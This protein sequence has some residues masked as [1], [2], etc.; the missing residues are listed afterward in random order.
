MGGRSVPGTR[1]RQ[2]SASWNAT[3]HPAGDHR[4]RDQGDSGHRQHRRYRWDA[5]AFGRRVTL[6][7]MGSTD[8]LLGGGHLSLASVLHGRDFCRNDL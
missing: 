6:A 7:A 5:P 2:V 1:R 3:I 8:R 4:Y